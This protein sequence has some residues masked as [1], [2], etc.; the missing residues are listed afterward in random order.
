MLSEAAGKS[1]GSSGSPCSKAFSLCF[2]TSRL[3]QHRA[4]AGGQDWLYTQILSGC[5]LTASQCVF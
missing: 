1:R 4:A 5:C 2:E 3:V